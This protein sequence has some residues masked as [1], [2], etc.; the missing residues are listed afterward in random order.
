L[1]DEALVYEKV[2][3]EDD[4]IKTRLDVY[5]RLPHVWW[6]QWP[7]LEESPMEQEDLNKRV[8]WLMEQA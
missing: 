3:R 7:E 8:K 5:P 2:L 1:C 6:L 4:R